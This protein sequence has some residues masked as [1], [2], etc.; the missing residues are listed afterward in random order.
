M[1]TRFS[2][3][4]PLTAFLVATAALWSC[5]GNVV[6]DTP[7]GGAGTGATGSTGAGGTSTVTSVTGTS[8]G[9]SSTGG[10]GT[11]VMSCPTPVP[12]GCGA[13][14]ECPCSDGTTQEGGCANGFTCPEACCGHGGSE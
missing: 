8:S 6:V 10:G 5:G 1:S 11:T 14:L 4:A 13:I 3:F 12:Q 7:T 2:R 9:V